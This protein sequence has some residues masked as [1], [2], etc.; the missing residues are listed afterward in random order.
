MFQVSP[1]SKP[2]N[3]PGRYCYGRCDMC[4]RED[5]LGRNLSAESRSLASGIQGRFCFQYFPLRHIVS[6]EGSCL[7]LLLTS[8]VVTSCICYWYQVILHMIRFSR[9]GWGSQGRRVCR[10]SNPICGITLI[11]PAGDSH[12]AS[13]VQKAPCQRTVALQQGLP[14]KNSDEDK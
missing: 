7:P 3:Y 14:V 10:L 5:S 2:P 8:S 9:S 6:W 12:I 1:I 11:T 4:G 13:G